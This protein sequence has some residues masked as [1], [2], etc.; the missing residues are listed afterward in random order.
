MKDA[1]G[2]RDAKVESRFWKQNR[3]DSV[4]RGDERRTGSRMSC[5]FLAQ[6]CSGCSDTEFNRNSYF[7]STKLNYHCGIQ[8]YNDN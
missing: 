2:N 6:T 3:E 7:S 5:R 4:S 8:I 1:S